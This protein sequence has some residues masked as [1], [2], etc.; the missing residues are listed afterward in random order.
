MLQL[1]EYSFIVGADMHTVWQASERSTATANK[2]Q[3]L[4]TAALQAWVESLGLMDVW[5]TFNPTLTDFSFFSARHKTSS[6]IDFLFSSP[7]LF[8]NINNVTLLPMALSDHKGVLSNVFIGSLSKKAARWRF[9]P[10]CWEMKIINHSLTFNY[11]I[12]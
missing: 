5:R 12:F 9:T 11:R 3:E 7:Q 2:D 4:A 10:H 6:R 1:T 8:Q